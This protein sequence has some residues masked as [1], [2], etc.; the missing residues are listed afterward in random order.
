MA[1]KVVHAPDEET[2]SQIA[3]ELFKYK[4]CHFKFIYAILGLNFKRDVIHVKENKKV[5]RKYETNIMDLA[6]NSTVDF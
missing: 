6:I 2:R 5:I 3:Y 4:E 1:L